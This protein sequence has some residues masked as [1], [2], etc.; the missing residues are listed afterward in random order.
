MLHI[1]YYGVAECCVLLNKGKYAG[2]TVDRRERISMNILFAVPYPEL[3]DVVKRV[4]SEVCFPEYIDFSVHV[5]TVDKLEQL[6]PSGYDAIIARGYSARYLQ[7]TYPSII[8]IELD[9]SGYDILRAFRYIH[10]NLHPRLVALFGSYKYMEASVPFAD[11]LGC[12]LRFYDV[13]DDADIHYNVDRALSDGCDLILSGYS[14]V[15][16]AKSLG[17]DGVIIQTGEEAVREAIDE[18]IQ[19]VTIK[20]NEQ[21][22]A[23]TYRLITK[24]STEG[25][26]FTDISGHIR[27]DNSTAQ[28][29][30]QLREP[31]CGRMINDIF[32][33]LRPAMDRVIETRRQKH[34]AVMGLR[35]GNAVTVTIT[36]VLGKNELYGMVINMLD[37]TYIQELE[38]N[39][40][41][42]LSEKGLRAKYHFSDIKY[43]SGIMK[44]VVEEAKRFAF[45]DANIL[46]NGETGTGKE[47]FAQS[48]HNESRRR[49]GPFV[50]VNCA[51][52]PENLL[53]SELFGYEEGA[54]T[55]SKRGGKMGLVEQAHRGTLFL[56]EIAEMPIELQSKLLRMLQE[57]EVR[58]IGSD[59]VISVD[60]RVI[61]ATNRDLEEEIEKGKFRQDLLYRLDVLRIYLPPLRDRREDIPLLFDHMIGAWENGASDS[62]RL[63]DAAM[64]AIAAYDY[65]GNVR[66]LRNIAERLCALYE[67][68]ETIDTEK[69]KQVLYPSSVGYKLSRKE[70]QK[71]LPHEAA[72]G[73]DILENKNGIGNEGR[74]AME[75]DISML[76][77]AVERAEYRQLMEALESCMWNRSR[78]AELLG[79]DRS[80]LWRK[81]KRYGIK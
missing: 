24:N 57:R 80:T 60:V 16:Y 81:L 47:L 38:G 14:A 76:H 40:R 9:I 2:S 66:E 27:V 21:M 43:R 28:E 49:N 58:R 69:I 11:M 1:C 64:S 37:I 56:D 35:S 29:M 71:A 62:Y 77:D 74:A 72:S 67:S 33:E 55:G 25:I 44:A 48:I 63:T 73:K 26:I 68:S 39:I 18:A 6:D 13:E 78:T 75:E 8:H 31:L 52:L 20:R 19:S 53:E 5:I 3:F 41:K 32:P 10:D 4:A 46:I 79:I 54:F 70:E 34:I 22:K 7:R 17:V 12:P 61:A 59:R 50:A 42:K 65:K 30:S 51:A 45:A 23:E 15:R 36:P